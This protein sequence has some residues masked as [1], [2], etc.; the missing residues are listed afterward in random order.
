MKLY[1]FIYRKIKKYPRLIDVS[2]QRWTGME[3]WLERRQKNNDWTIEELILI[4]CL[5][6]RIRD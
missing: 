2:K 6:R 3:L 1:Q 4:D 5:E